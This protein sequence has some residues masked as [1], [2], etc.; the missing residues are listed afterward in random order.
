[1]IPLALGLFGFLAGYAVH[2]WIRRDVERLR[3]IEREYREAMARCEGIARGGG[4][5][6]CWIGG[7]VAKVYKYG[8]LAPTENADLVRQQMR[9]AHRYRNTLVEIERARRAAAREVVSI[10]D[11]E[12]TK[13]E[14]LSELKAARAE[15]RMERSKH[16]ARAE[17]DVMKSRVDLAKRRLSEAGSKLKEAKRLAK[18]DPS[19]AARFDEIGSLAATLRRDA[20]TLS[21]LYWGTYEVV[22]AAD[23]QSRNSKTDPR[24]VRWNGEGQ[25]G[26]RIKNGA[27]C[28][29]LTD[30]RRLRIVGEGRK[31]ELW[32]RVGSEGVA[33][34]WA[35]FP[36]VYHRPIPPGSRIKCAR[37]NLRRI[38]PR[39][40]WSAT[41]TLDAVPL[42]Q[43][44]TG[45]IA[46]DIGWRKRPGGIRVQTW[47]DESG[48]TGEMLLDAS[49]F[50]FVDG[51]RRVR[52]VNFNSALS[53]LLRQIEGLT[54]PDWFP[55]T[56]GQWQSP[57]RLAALAKKWKES[58]FPGDTDAYDT[59]ESWRYHDQHIS[60]WESSSR[61]TAC[62]DRRERYRVFASKAAKT[63]KVAVFED[64]DMR[65]KKPE[66]G[67]RDDTA[68]NAAPKTN[69]TIAAI[70][71]FRECVKNA[72]L[73]RGGEVA[74]V[75]PA[76]TSRT[77]N[78]CGSLGAKLTPEC[79]VFECQQCGHTADRDE[80]A[81]RNILER[82][83]TGQTTKTVR[84]K[85]PGESRWAKVR[86]MKAEREAARDP[87]DKAA[88]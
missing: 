4:K 45:A 19:V 63:Y 69:K 72:F 55:K 86:R 81:A 74:F 39:E 75:D 33:P 12:A 87:S 58:R 11:L 46:F 30:H 51:L 25:I 6:W 62:R 66:A 10:P 29:E 68:Q 80:N 52:T 42:G 50:D 32:I 48:A 49:A 17:T 61:A 43:C 22:N 38:G 83:R 23:E 31:R 59:L 44:G 53:L 28:D 57:D 71:E 26:V 16:R 60:E 65:R 3:D 82:F 77:C 20:Q 88:E 27:L 13:N 76:Y 54:L 47:A 35:K 8:L 56:V 34:I 64:F 79:T 21:G 9:L 70:G 5:W 18:E 24:F 73:S 14:A 1:M 15:I 67:D 2:A 37:V 84:V 85:E 40:V 36:M 7:V 41:F 78:S